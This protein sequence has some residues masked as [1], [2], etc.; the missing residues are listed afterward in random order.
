MH[1]SRIE[2]LANYVQVEL[3]ELFI[4]Q[5]GIA[6]SLFCEQVEEQLLHIL[7]RVV[8]LEVEIISQENNVVFSCIS[9]KRFSYDNVM[10]ELKVTE[11][12]TNSNILQITVRGTNPKKTKFEK[13][14]SK[15]SIDSLGRYNEIQVATD[16]IF[17][18]Q[19]AICD[20]A[21]LVL[22]AGYRWLSEYVRVALDELQDQI[23]DDLYSHLRRLFP[24]RIVENIFLWKAVD[25]KGVYVPDDLARRVAI[26]RAS[27]RKFSSSLSPIEIITT[28][29]T[30]T[31]ELDKLV[32]RRAVAE[33]SIIEGNFL[34]AKYADS[35]LDLAE[36]V[37]YQSQRFVAHPVVRE[38]K[39]LLIAGYPV[40]IRPIVES[41]LRKE[42]TNFQMILS[43]ESSAILRKV[44]EVKSQGA[45]PKLD[46]EE[47]PN[48]WIVRTVSNI[49]LKPNIW[50]VGFNLNNIILEIL[51]K[52][53]QRR[54]KN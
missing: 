47:L 50:G 7:R 42:R 27:K 28:F 54:K 1:I 49:E 43:R 45:L 2:D 35:G 44:E 26:N 34:D 37:I 33:D 32:S 17:N 6:L 38:G 24:D 21:K 8:L 41:V 3:D 15:T 22:E 30:A 4:E 5:R 31:V 11:Y 48:T 25:R 10:F 14:P 53:Y 51:K 18:Y 29:S 40:E 36:I 16:K 9:L 12:A 52:Y 46:P 39:V 19:A 23:A 20:V 13:K